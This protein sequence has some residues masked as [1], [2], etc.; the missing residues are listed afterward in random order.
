MKLVPF[1]LRVNLIKK[2]SLKNLQIHF[3]LL[4]LSEITVSESNNHVLSRKKKQNFLDSISY[5]GTKLY[6]L[7]PT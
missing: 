6:F 4:C 5:K 2:K 7:L 3:Y 1:A